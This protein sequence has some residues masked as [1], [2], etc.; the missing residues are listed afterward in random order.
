M[1]DRA[2]VGGDAGVLAGV[3]EDEEQ[4]F[5]R[6][7]VLAEGVEREG[8]EDV[9][10]AVIGKLGAAGAENFGGAG[11]LAGVPQ[12]GTEAEEGTGEFVGGEAEGDG[13][14]V[15]RDGLGGVAERVRGPRELVG[16]LGDVRKTRVEFPEQAEDVIDLA[17]VARADD[18]VEFGFP[19][20]GVG[21]RHGVR[22]G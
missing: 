14:F 21:G 4:K 1:A 8:E 19:G 13:A 7:S 10:L 16:D 18:G 3:G 15:V 22:G 20:G 12:G 17:A 11:E 5:G 6:F 2:L 9:E